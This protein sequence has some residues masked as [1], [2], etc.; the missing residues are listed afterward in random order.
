M[1]SVLLCAAA[2]AALALSGCG[3]GGGGSSSGGSSSGGSGGSGGGVTPPAPTPVSATQISNKD[4]SR[5]FLM[6]AGWGGSQTEIDA[7]VGTDAADWITA[8]MAL[9]ESEIVPVMR[10]G[11]PFASGGA[12]NRK[13]WWDQTLNDED[14]LRSRMVFALSQIIVASNLNDGNIGNNQRIAAYMDSLG[15]HAFGNYRDLLEEITYSGHMA[16]F[17][18]YRNNRKASDD[19]LRQPDENYAR[20]I[21]QLF[22]IGLV[23]LNADGTVK[24]GADGEPV[25]TYTNEDVTGLARVFTG[26]NYDF[27]LTT[28]EERNFNP[29]KIQS[30]WHSEKEKRFLGATIP[31]GTSGEASVTQA[32]DTIF[33]HPNVAPFISSQLIQRFTQST[34]SPAYV[35]RVSAAF[36]EGRF[37]TGAGDRFGTGRRGDLAATLAAILLDPQ[38]FDDIAPGPDEGKVREPILRFVHWVKAMEV[39]NP[40]GSN[41]QSVYR[42]MNESGRGISQGA[43]QSPSVFNFYRPGFKSPGSE[44]AAAGLTAPELQLVQ[45]GQIRGYYDFMFNLV[46]GRRDRDDNSIDSFRATYP[47][48]TALADEPAALVDQVEDLLISGS[49]EA[50][51]RQRIIDAVTM[52]PVRNTNLAADRLSR[53][54]IAVYMAV[55]SVEYGMQY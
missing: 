22:S 16:N 55:T 18:T 37:T 49:F 10:A 43:F 8:Q 2:A 27:S 53:A 15:R 4:Q 44:S 3:G 47:A 45:E 1:R 6:R 23:E 17:L 30:Q 26:L 25:E 34:P 9:P 52:S 7:L 50:T 39:A 51:T 5:D 14:V 35:S 41:E 11:G 24:T 36:E 38:F 12:M 32:L 20:E 21:M 31:A 33:A 54:K 13:I 48:L 46:A 40:Q 19:G 29:L 42:Y 28:T